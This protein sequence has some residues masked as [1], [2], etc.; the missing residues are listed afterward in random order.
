MNCRQFL[1]VDLQ[2]LYNCE[3][4]RSPPAVRSENLFPQQHQIVPR[5]PSWFL[6]SAG[7]RSP[8]RPHRLSS[9][10]TLKAKRKF[11]AY[12]QYNSTA[13]TECKLEIPPPHYLYI[14]QAQR[15]L[16][17]KIELS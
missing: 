14:Q 7:A 16:F 17:L 15:H 1:P 12:L 13:K 5:F 8:D 3:N 10:P 9:L 11:P 2:H 6:G 4:W